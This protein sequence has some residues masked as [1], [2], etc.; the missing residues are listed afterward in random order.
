MPLVRYDARRAPVDAIDEITVLYEEFTAIRALLAEPR[1]RAKLELACSW[2][3][4][5]V[6][7]FEAIEP[8]PPAAQG[9]AAC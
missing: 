5:W 2:A 9:A 1:S 4:E 6:D 3:Q 8:A 7:H